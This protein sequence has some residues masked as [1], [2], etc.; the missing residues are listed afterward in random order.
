MGTEAMVLERYSKPGLFA[1]V[2][3]HKPRKEKTRDFLAKTFTKAEK[4]KCT[5][6]VACE[7]VNKTA[8]LAV[9]EIEAR[10]GNFQRTV[11]PII[12]SLYYQKGYCNFAYEIIKEDENPYLYDAPAHILELLTP[13]RSPQGKRWREKCWENAKEKASRGTS[14]GEKKER[15]ISLFEY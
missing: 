14:E 7:I 5:R 8:Y 3:I 12:C 10:N 9:E 1:P 13:P 6:V 4:G 15:Q 11:Y 2:Y